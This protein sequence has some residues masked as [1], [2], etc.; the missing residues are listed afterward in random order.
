ML[1]FAIYSSKR[2]KSQKSYSSKHLNRQLPFE[3]Y[4]HPGR[5]QPQ[6]VMQSPRLCADA[7]K[8]M[9]LALVA[10]HKAMPPLGPPWKLVSPSGVLFVIASDRRPYT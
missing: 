10:A 4:I 6:H 1:L 7:E 2:F 9:I 8:R 5:V 3:A